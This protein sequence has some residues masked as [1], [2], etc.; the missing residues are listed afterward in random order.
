MKTLK[1]T[2]TILALFFLLLT[3]DAQTFSDSQQAEIESFQSKASAFSFISSQNQQTTR[4]NQAANGSSV[5]INQIGSNNDAQVKVNAANSFVNLLQ[6]GFSNLTILDLTAFDI[7]QNITQ[8]GENNRL[9]NFSNNPAS[10]QN[11]EV[12]QNGINQ[13][14]TIFGSNSLSENI[15]INMQGSDRSLIVR[16]FN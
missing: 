11:M 8:N 5:F 1:S 9:F 2:L 7:T 13:D 3:V 14:I 6:N 12:L 10:I 15:K 4:G 16:N